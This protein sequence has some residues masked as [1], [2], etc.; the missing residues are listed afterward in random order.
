MADYLWPAGLAPRA[1]SFYLQP[2]TGGTASPFSRITKTYELSAP[3][4]VCRMSFLGGYDG[5]SGIQA[6]G[7]V[8][9]GLFAR[10]RGRANRIGVFDFRRPNMR[11]ADTSGAGNLAASAGAFTMTIT[12]LAPGE[13][14]LTGD[15]VGGDGR[16][17]I[18]V[19]D[20]IVDG[21]GQAQVFFEP[22]LR[23]PVGA[24]AAVFGDPVG[25]FR[26]QS[27]DTGANP[28]QV[29]EAVSY[30]LDLLEDPLNAPLIFVPDLTLTIGGYTVLV[31]GDTVEMA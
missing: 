18:L 19:A 14:L 4:W 27:E 17:H 7:A 20:A 13:V 2:H 29:G 25:W 16:P 24:N 9:D 23:A 10:L 22:A 11:G 8:L 30:D 5:A 21:A 12:G 28:V 3:L 26:L 15:Y 6:Y 31:A 1:V